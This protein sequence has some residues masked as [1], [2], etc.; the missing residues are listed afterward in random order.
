MTIVPDFDDWDAMVSELK[1]AKLFTDSVIDISKFLRDDNSINLQLLD[2]AIKHIVSN[3]NNYMFTIF[4]FAKY[5]EERGIMGMTSQIDQE[6]TFI[7]NYVEKVGYEFRE[8][9]VEVLWMP[10]ETL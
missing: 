4:G 6:E 8:N 1:E 7:I 9:D 2:V 3:C 10:E 5:C